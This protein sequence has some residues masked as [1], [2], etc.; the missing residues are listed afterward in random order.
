[1]RSFVFAFRGIVLAFREEAN[2]WFHGMASLVVIAAGFYFDLKSW[3]WIALL[4]AIAMVI[5][6]EIM[7][8]AIETLADRVTTEKDSMIAKAKDLA[9]GAVLVTAIIAAAIGGIIFYPYLMR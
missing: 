4:I 6:M 1:M 2:M 7:N 8:T 3:E 9:A 5:S